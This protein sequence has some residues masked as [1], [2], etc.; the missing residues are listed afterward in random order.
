MSKFN[1]E[2]D[3]NE[4]Y[5]ISVD[6]QN[7]MAIYITTVK[8]EESKNFGNPKETIISYNMNLIN[9]IRSIVEDMVR[10]EKPDDIGRL[11]EMMGWYQGKQEALLDT[12]LLRKLEKSYRT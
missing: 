10:K 6:A 7:W 8:D 1:V 12:I 9:C 5:K 3:V 4:D 2:I 11:E